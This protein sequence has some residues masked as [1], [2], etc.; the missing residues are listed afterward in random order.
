[1]TLTDAAVPDDQ[2]ILT[3][4]ADHIAHI[5]FNNPARHNAM[6]LS[7]WQGLSTRLAEYARD[8]DVRVVVL[9]GAG[10]KAFVSGA[11]IS[12]FGTKRSSGDTVALYNRA[13]ND[14]EAMVADFPKPII[15]KIDGY[16]LGGGLGL[17]ISC[18][19]RICSAVS[20]FSIPAGKLG[21]G[22]DYAGVAKLV[23]VVGPAAAAEL[24]YSGQMFSADDASRL[25]LINR[26]IP[27]DGFDQAVD[28]FCMAVAQNAPLTMTAFKAAL[29]ERGKPSSERDTNRVQQMVETCYASDDYREGRLAFAEKRPPIFT[30]A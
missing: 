12:E 27:Q 9:S 15:A 11:D 26:V 18:D 29:L 25:G 6:S 16:C 20:R 13:T 24:F 14:A 4:C 17:A 21:L 30:G 2:R 8:D 10:G 5:V 1:M 23:D 3:H 22:Y 7:M 19:I 28:E